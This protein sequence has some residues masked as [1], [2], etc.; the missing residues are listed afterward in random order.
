MQ[1]CLVQTAEYL[2]WHGVL[3]AISVTFLLMLLQ[4]D[5]GLALMTTHDKLL[6]YIWSGAIMTCGIAKYQ[7]QA[8]EMCRAEC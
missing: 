5:A 6:P 4:R 1:L 8:R 3:G 2:S 7:Q